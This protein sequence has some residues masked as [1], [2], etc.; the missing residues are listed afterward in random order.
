MNSHVP[1]DYKIRDQV[2]AAIIEN[3]NVHRIDEEMQALMRQDI[4]FLKAAEQIDAVREFIGSPEK[5]LGNMATKHGEI[6]EQVE[7]GVRNARDALAQVNMGATFDG[8]GRLAQEDYIVDGLL[9]QSKFING[10]N[11]TLQHV[12]EHM[13]KYENF[14]R[15][16]SYYHIP[17]DQ[18]K[19]IQ[20]IL[21]GESSENLSQRSIDA[22]RD[23]VTQ[24]EAVTGKPF[25]VAVRPGVSDYAE[26]QTGKVS[27]TLDK[28]A[29]DLKSQNEDLK[30]NI[31][32][33]HKASFHEG[34]QAAA[35]AAAV[36]AA[37][38]FFS[39]TYKKY[40][41]GKNIFKGDFDTQ[42]WKDVGL[43]ALKGGIAGG[44][45]GAA[46]YALTNSAQLSAPFAGAFVSAVKGVGALTKQ[47]HAGEINMDQFI[48]SGLLVCS[49]S[50]IVGICTVLGQSL[51]PI[52]VL[53]A[54]IGSIAGKVL[55]SVA[56]KD[57]NGLAL[58]LDAS[59]RKFRT[60]L[61]NTYNA[62][63]RKIE[64]EF[65]R[66]GELTHAAFDF[67][68][69]VKLLE[70]S[71]DLARAYGVNEARLIKSHIELDNLMFS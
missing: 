44:A 40:R 11:N 14:G 6:A 52:P 20:N 18:Y 51:I 8:V 27:E 66:L 26:V 65:D 13:E 56:S 43:D 23:K 58:K 39:G 47:L 12:L 34:V 17:K 30:N 29:N 48:D 31:S 59:M 21:N 36:G 57:V 50:A 54:V 22:L 41:G 60:I 63:I 3:V 71:L 10:A 32:D 62:L 15:D 69:N 2:S 64:M 45:S 70:S 19:T 49:E 7:V 68:N 1:L 53:G 61:D 46:I 67:K 28:H 35:G 38:C 37:I 33:N 55:A 4:A 24:I 42:D 5:I 25:D 9:V 16:D